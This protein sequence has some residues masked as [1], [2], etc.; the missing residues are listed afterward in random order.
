[1]KRL[2]ELL[3]LLVVTLPL[4]GQSYGVANISQ[5][6][7]LPARCSVGSFFYK[8]DAPAGQNI[9][10]CTSTDVWTL[11]AGGGGLADPGGNGFLDRTALNVTAARTLTGT[12]SEIAVAN[13]GGGGDP[14]IS[15]ADTFRI[16]GKTAT[17]PMK[18]GT[19]L[20]GTCTTGDLFYKSDA[21]AG[22]N[23]Y[24]CTNTNVWTLQAGSGAGDVL[25]PATN[26]DNFIPQWNGA[27]SKTLKNGLQPA[28]TNTASSL[29]QRDGS[30]NFAAGTISATLAGNAD[31]STALAS[32][33]A[34]CPAGQ[35]AVG[36]TANG[37][38]TCKAVNVINVKTDYAATGDGSTDDTTAISNAITAAA[39]GSRLMFPPGTYIASAITIA[40]ALKIEGPGTIKLKN[41]AGVTDTPFISVTAADVEF[42]RITID[43]NKANQG[44]TT[45]VALIQYGNDAD[46]GKVV[47]CT[48]INS[49]GYLVEFLG[50]HNMLIDG[51]YGAVWET[52]NQG[53]IL[54]NI[55]GKNQ[56]S[57]NIRIVNNYLDGSTSNSSGIKVH[58]SS[59]YPTTNVVIANNTIIV[60]DAAE[61]TLGIEIYTFAAGALSGAVISGN[62][63]KGENN[64]NLLI[65]GISVSGTAI[66]TTSNISI[67]G[68]TMY[69]CRYV[70]LELKASSDLSAVGNTITSTAAAPIVGV[71]GAYINETLHVSFTGNVISGY[72]RGL[73]IYGAGET[74]AYTALS[75]IQGNIF[76]LPAG[77]AGS[78]IYILSNHAS[79]TITGSI[80][81]GNFFIGNTTTNQIGISFVQAAGSIAQTKVTD[82][83]FWAL[84]TG[85]VHGSQ[86]YTSVGENSYLNVTTRESG[87]TGT[88]LLLWD[89]GGGAYVYAG[90]GTPSNGS[91][92]FCSDCTIANPCA[93]S[94]TGAIAKRLNGV[95]VCN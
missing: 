80:I 94:G 46:N 55:T 58:G 92:V 69:D 29:V 83:F 14:T 43:G 93:G 37:T 33:P 73:Q 16:T 36:V 21:T 39:A 90:L 3:A 60:G 6:T 95:W 48:L 87:S 75:N 2:Q 28:S 64:T 84:A 38:A 74:G 17:A 53:A 5:G 52:G 40:K 62:V 44:A 27:D 85:I 78:A 51:N 79:A 71:P 70:G 15:V 57:S 81:Q 9:Y 47:N 67:T 34:D 63:I 8:T 49:S 72:N 35:R 13:G 50:V 11:Q 88:G 45:G 4:L 68:N 77:Q 56:A 89:N 7:T 91:I 19:S 54:H 76:R 23:I 26:T 22:Q 1:M 31:T 12:A 41:G 32:D 86:T 42:Y 59:T 20:P 61:W 25:G 66:Y 82:N 65:M 18:V 10:G 30:G 24:G